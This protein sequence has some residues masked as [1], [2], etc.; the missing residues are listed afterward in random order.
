MTLG[1]VTT[2]PGESSDSSGPGPPG[3]TPFPSGGTRPAEAPGSLD[4]A[5]EVWQPLFDEL[6]VGVVVVLPDGRV[7]L[8][9]R[10]LAEFFDPFTVDEQTGHMTMDRNRL[11]L[12]DGRPVPPGTLPLERC[13]AEGR[14]V[15]ARQYLYHG[16]DGDKTISVDATPVCAED[17][18]ILAHATTVVDETT[19]RRFLTELGEIQRELDTHI[20]ELNRVH[21]LIERLSSRTEL[22]ELLQETA[23][24][25]GELDGADIVAIFLADDG[26][27]RLTASTGMTEQQYRVID[28][29]D[30]ADLYT[31]QRAMAGLSTTIVDVQQEAGMS[32]PYRSALD[33]LNAVSI[34]GLPLRSVEGQPLGSIVSVFQSVRMPSPHQRQLVETCGRVVAQL[35]VNARMRARD[36]NLAASLQHSMMQ[37]HLPSVP[38]GELATFYRAGST[39]MYAGGDWF[40]ASV[41]DD[42]RLSLVI[43]DVVGHGL[44]AVM[45]MGRMR[46][47]VRAYVVGEEGSPVDPL[48]LARLL[49]RWS[50]VTGGGEASTACFTQ[51]AP[52]GVC[53]LAG[54]GHPPPLVVAPDG[55]ARFAYEQAPGPPLGLLGLTGQNPA[56]RLELEPGATLMLYTD[57]LVE[58]RGEEITS[59]LTRLRE[60]AAREI[61]GTPPGSLGQACECIARE[62]APAHCTDDDVAVLAFTLRGP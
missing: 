42:G 32:G 27:L 22:G 5:G 37:Q 55:Q 36:R 57:G 58:R 34:Y 31:S 47:A 11:S 41:L 48:Q 23:Q 19:N 45:M 21:R 1:R 53:I 24:V 12:P 4:R 51:V 7:L 2:D 16:R 18:T 40:Q 29:L 62:C 6:S 30:A 49:D 20:R 50:V 26:D 25:V 15:E 28:E 8:T 17:G 61:P 54:A 3:L 43:G 44:D 59:G 56:L 52:D 39:D 60:V 14:R 46:S 10:W 9:N 33:Q 38:W 13:L 35:I